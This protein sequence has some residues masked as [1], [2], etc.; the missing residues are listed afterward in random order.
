MRWF[1][2]VA[3]SQVQEK[4]RSVTLAQEFLMKALVSAFALLTFVAGTTLPL[5]SYAQTSMGGGQTMSPDTS[6]SMPPTTTT[7]KKKKSK[8]HHTKKKSK[9]S[10]TGQTSSVKPKHSRHGIS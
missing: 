10:S 9:K 8:S 3:P 6:T 1:C 7:K 4:R 2:G 5:E